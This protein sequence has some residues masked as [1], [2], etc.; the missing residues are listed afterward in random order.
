[1]CEL[2]ERTTNLL[3]GL[4]CLELWTCSKFA[5]SLWELVWCDWP[6]YPR[7]RLYNQ[8][9]T[10]PLSVSLHDNY[11]E[12]KIREGCQVLII[13]FIHDWFH[14]KPHKSQLIKL[15]S[16]YRKK[17]HIRNWT[18]IIFIALHLLALSVYNHTPLCWPNAETVF[19]KSFCRGAKSW[20][21]SHVGEK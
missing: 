15:D 14:C 11:C 7:F 2:T 6:L 5:G 21:V 17:K 3:N 19:T 12:R 16:V 20:E 10:Q 18:A 8:L 13:F 4:G 9:W 1:M